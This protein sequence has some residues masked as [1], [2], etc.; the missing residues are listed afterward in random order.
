MALKLPQ[1]YNTHVRSQLILADTTTPVVEDLPLQFKFVNSKMGRSSRD[2]IGCIQ[3]HVIPRHATSCHVIFM[4][5]QCMR[6]RNA[7]VE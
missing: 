5:S 3:I 1:Q 2:S 4:A 6:E 7:Y